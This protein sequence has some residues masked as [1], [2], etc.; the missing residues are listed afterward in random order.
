MPA[1][2]QKLV[3]MTLRRS[4]ELGRKVGMGFVFEEMLE[5]IAQMEDPEKRSADLFGSHE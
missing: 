4:I 2:H 1:S 3:Q 5:Q